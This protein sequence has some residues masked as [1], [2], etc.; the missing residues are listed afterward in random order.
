M[1]LTLMTEV[2]ELKH[3]QA[4]STTHLEALVSL[5]K[6]QEATLDRAARLILTLADKLNDHEKR[7]EALEARQ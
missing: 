4:E 2:A 5:S 7:L 3:N 1:I 6:K